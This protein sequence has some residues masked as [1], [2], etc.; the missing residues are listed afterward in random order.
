MADRCGDLGHNRPEFQNLCRS[1]VEYVPEILAVLDADGKILYVNPQTEKVLGYRPDDVEGRD[2]FELVHPADLQRARQEYSV[3]ISQDGEQIPSFLRIRDNSGEWIPFEI[4]ANN[5]LRDPETRA[6]IFAAR[7]LRFRKEIEAAIL[8]ANADTEAE[9]AKRTTE[10]TK[11]NAELRIENQARRQAESRLQHTISLLH[12]TLDSTADGILVVSL[13]GE[14]T[15]CNKKFAEMWRL[16]CGPSM[17][18]DDQA[19]LARVSDQLQR[20]RDFLDKV[21]LLYAD[22]AATSFDVL[23]FRDGRIFER[24]SQPQLLDQNINGRVWSFRDVT[25]ARNLEAELRQSQKMESLGKLAGGVAHDFNNL[26]MLITGYASQAAE[27][28]RAPGKWHRVKQFFVSQSPYR[29]Q[30]LEVGTRFSASLQQEL[31]FGYDTQSQ[32]QL[33][34]LG[35]V[36]LAD[37]VLHARLLLEVSSATATRGSPVVAELTQPVYSANHQLLLPCG[38]RL[39]GQVVEA[40]PARL[41]RRN[42][43]LRVIFEHIEMPGGNL[44]EVQGTLEGIEVARSAHLRLDEEGGAHA[45]D[46]KTRYLST[47]VALLMAA[48][49]AHPDVERGTVDQ[50]GDPAVRA[51]AGASGFGL[52]GT[53]IGLASKSNAVSIVFSAYGAS[54]SIYSNFLSRGRDVVLPKNVPMEIGLGAPHPGPKQRQR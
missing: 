51:G 4:I 45:T 16:D 22:P 8:R 53:L 26:L 40:R 32:D 30:Y 21:R 29:R 39:I 42:G 31:D 9:V 5:R 33:S 34:Q 36:P 23:F 6:V 2:I 17:E 19:L 18:K 3:T 25:R 14:V 49:A 7:D 52:A 43:E 38:S 54:A 11:I 27:Q 24:Y 20:P 46:S 44:Q 1:V 37:T 47:G 48:V 15:I 50:A 35:S 12:A 13:D 28:I 10:L 41:L